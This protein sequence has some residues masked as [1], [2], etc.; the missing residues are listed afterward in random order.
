M[1]TRCVFA[2]VIGVCVAALTACNS[3]AQ[4]PDSAAKGLPA[5]EETNPVGYDRWTEMNG[6]PADIPEMKIMAEKFGLKELGVP[7]SEY[8]DQGVIGVA[9]LERYCVLALTGDMGS[10][11]QGLLDMTLMSRYNKTYYVMMPSLPTE[12]IPKMIDKYR[13]FCNGEAELQLEPEPTA[14]AA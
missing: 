8:F 12:N 5:I 11:S 14:E 1:N 2:L 6:G 10:A 13:A 7:T 3:S 9:R 4:L